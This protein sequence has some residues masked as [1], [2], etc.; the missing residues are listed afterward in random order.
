MNNRI[1]RSLAPTLA[2]LGLLLAG[3]TANSVQIVRF[4]LISPVIVP[5]VDAP[6]QF[7]MNVA[8]KNYS[9]SDTAP[10]LW[11]KI[12]AE[13]WSSVEH[14]QGQ[15]P[16]SYAD[17][18]HIGALA[19]GQGWALPDYRID[20]GNDSCL[21]LKD[22]CPG[23]VWLDLHVAPEYPPHFAGPNTALHVN[24]VP[25]GDLAGETVKEF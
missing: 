20:R 16:C 21:C 11:L 23:H 19:P 25:S 15:P 17:W 10:D 24:W 13:Y 2:A 18:V 1:G 14:P 6:Q 8:V 4:P 7:L 22:A 3:C 9:T 5:G 12:Y